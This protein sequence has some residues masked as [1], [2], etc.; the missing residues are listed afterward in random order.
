MIQYK[1][2]ERFAELW[3]EAWF[4]AVRPGYPVAGSS[5]PLPLHH[6]FFPD[7]T[8]GSHFTQHEPLPCLARTQGAH[9]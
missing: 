5:H 4:L 8:T 6:L 3:Q 2:I 7:D 1:Q 9:W